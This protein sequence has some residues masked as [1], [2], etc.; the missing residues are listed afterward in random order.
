MKKLRIVFLLMCFLVPAIFVGCNKSKGTLSSPHIYEISG[1]TIV[2]S[3]VSNADYYT[4][5]ING[6]ELTVDAENSSY[7]EIIDNKI[8]YDASKIFTVG[9]EYIV[10]IKA[11]A[12]KYNSS[13][14]SSNFK[15]RHHGNI[16]KPKNLK[17]NGTTLTWD[18]VEN[19]H[20]YIIKIVTP[21]DIIIYD[22][23]GDIIQQDN[24]TTIAKADVAEHN[25]STNQFNFS[26]LLSSA[27]T[28]KF[29]VCS[30]ISDDSKNVE[31]AYSD[32]LEYSHTVALSSPVNS[33][34]FL[35]DGKIMMRTIVDDKANAIS[36]SCNGVEKTTKFL[37][38]D[39]SMTTVADNV[40]DIDLKKYFKT[41]IE[42]GKID[43]DSPVQ[44]VFTTQ[45]KY[46]TD[47]GKSNYINSSV[48]KNVVFNNTLQLA[49]PELT[50]GFSDVDNCYVA[51]WTTEDAFVAE[52]NL[53]VATETELLTFELD[54]DV[55]KM[56]L[57]KNFVGVSIQAVGRGD[58]ESSFPCQ[59]I[60]NPD[61]GTTLD[62]T[63][64]SITPTE[65]SWNDVGADYYVLTVGEKT[66]STTQTSY[67]L[68]TAFEMDKTAVSLVAIKSGHAP[69]YEKSI[70][71][72]TSKLKSPTFNSTQGFNSKNIYELTFTGSENALGYYVYLK[73]ENGGDFIKIP[74]MFTSTKIDLTQYIISQ[75][76]AN[77][78]V[79]LLAVAPPKNNGAGYL[80]S[81]FSSEVTVTHKKVLNAPE[82]NQTN[83]ILTPI[84]KFY[85]GNQSKYSL[86]FKGVEDAGSY[87]VLIN[88]NRIVINADATAPTKCYD[89]NITNYL[90]TANLYNIKV[91]ALPNE[92]DHFMQASHFV[93][94]NY[95]VRKQL[96]TVTNV[97]IDMTDGVYTLMFDL[98]NNAESYLVR[99]TKENDGAYSDYLESIGKS[100]TFEI[101]H[102]VDVTEYVKQQG[103]YYFYI[104]ALASENSSSFYSDS[105]ESK[106]AKVDK[107]TSLNAPTDIT[108]AGNLN[109]TSFT[110]RW[111]GDEHAD[112]YLIR[113]E[114]PDGTTSEE[115]IHGADCTQANIEKYMT[116]QGNYTITVA[117]QITAL[118]PNSTEYTASVGGVLTFEYK[119]ETEQDFKRYSV[120]NYGEKT[121]FLVQNVQELKN[122]LWFYYLYPQDNYG[123][124]FMLKPT[125]QFVGLS[126]SIVDLADE[127]TTLQL[128]NFAADE[129]WTN[130]VN[131]GSATPNDLMEYVCKA[132]LSV[133]PEF[134]VLNWTGISSV[135]NIF[136]VEYF[137]ALDFDLDATNPNNPHKLTVE[138]VDFLSE[139]APSQIETNSNFGTKQTYIDQFSRRSPS[140]IF[141]IDS[142]PEMLVS[143]TEQLMHAVQNN[144]K[145]KFV[146]NCEVAK[147][148][149]NNAKLVLSAIVT[150]NMSDLE[151]TEAI[152][153]WISNCFDLTY[154]NFHSNRTISGEVEKDDMETFGRY[155]QYYLEGIFEDISVLENGDLEIGNK[156]A[157]SFSYSK[158]FALLCS[159]EGIEA[160]VVNGNY[161]H[162]KTNALH[163]WNKVKI[164]TTS[165]LVNKQ[166]FAVDITFSD[167]I[168]KFNNLNSGYGVSSHAFFLK[169]DTYDQTTFVKKNDL[170]ALISQNYKDLRKCETNYDYYL[171]SNFAMTFEQIDATIDNFAF[172]D[173]SD[174]NYSLNYSFVNS[175]YYQDYLG[176]GTEEHGE[177]QMFLFNA[178][179]Y[180]KFKADT[181]GTGRGMFEFTFDFAKYNNG[182]SNLTSNPSNPLN[183]VFQTLRNSDKGYNVKLVDNLTFAD[184]QFSTLIFVV[185]KV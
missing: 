110:L 144:R 34:V 1:G 11:H 64:M 5:S 26:N 76:Y 177:L 149:Y 132:L 63:D 87:E 137:N 22:K 60:S 3:S 125:N 160:I 29:Y 74:I 101:T 20:Y 113:I 184:A 104:T 72:P 39:T 44:F 105:N 147:N 166:W 120:Y 48:S 75:D 141:A 50:V 17:V 80:D 119:F 79:K 7:V 107:L 86:K 33:Q 66:I 129:T 155:K 91:R 161:S 53:F 35:S 54:S 168:V 145:P 102:A 162:E 175:G 47:D 27:G 172:D 93:E 96:D 15:Y 77:Y 89:V 134:H 51:S 78:K 25:L 111:T 95:V 56:L 68:E 57:P 81:D 150:N 170:S 103:T 45:C 37:S 2:F 41:Q 94:T 115:T 159:I 70:V 165:D 121:N 49:E 117:S 59:C 85:E 128:H 73:S 40:V 14:F 123:L 71:T 10:Q 58:Y 12:K 124:T 169:N 6:Y 122:L 167:N 135:N 55:D 136:K 30:A 171:N 67:A 82:F 69:K 46:E 4:I 183:S 31:S 61:L 13:D 18:T 116:I 140:G 112:K 158:A 92:L 65:I 146:G 19:A 88:Y 156:Y 90:K 176:F 131:S 84:V 173:T 179:I 126:N 185:E 178:L 97:E 9:D 143:T 154:Y 16:S 38:T 100:S 152:F 180:A 164:A 148:V 138:K 43:F 118:S 127:A 21:D 174:F 23:N 36:I 142:R 99:V 52:F 130:M 108:V 32:R 8:N 42:E 109:D 28:Y 157:T 182:I 153:N 24:P 133:Y 98:V 139:N 106:H 181:N 83:G 163:A 151:K 62:S 114:S